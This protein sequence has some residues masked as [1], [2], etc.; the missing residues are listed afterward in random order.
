MPKCNSELENV[1]E[2]SVK[3][4]WPF[5]VQDEPSEALAFSLFINKV[6]RSRIQIRFNAGSIRMATFRSSCFVN[7]ENVAGRL[8]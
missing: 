1:E 7:S 5:S 2:N 8:G 3:L 6:G 4:T